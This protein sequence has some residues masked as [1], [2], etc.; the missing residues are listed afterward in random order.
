MRAVLIGGI[1][2]SMQALPSQR[3]RTCSQML[4][5]RCSSPKEKRPSKKAR[6]SGEA[7]TTAGRCSQVALRKA[8]ASCRSDGGQEGNLQLRP[9]VWFTHRPSHGPRSGGAGGGGGD[10]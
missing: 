6:R 7:L 2:P 3:K 4:H 5:S 1:D 8:D 9:Q 10:G